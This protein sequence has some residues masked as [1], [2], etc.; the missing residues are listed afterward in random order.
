M[1]RWRQL[2]LHRAAVP[3]WSALLAAA[4][5][6]PFLGRG[7][8]LSYDMVWVPRLDLDRPEIWG[9]GTGLPRAVPSDAVVALLGAAVPA[10]VVQRLVL[11]AGLFLLAVGTA[12]LL[13]ERPLVAQLAAATLAVWNPFIAERL[14]L[15]QWPLLLACAAFPWLIDALG[16]KHDP[17]WSVASLALAATA[18][19][20]AT[21]VMGLVLALVAAW[22]RGVVGVVVLAALVN[23]PWVVAGLLHSSISRSDP[24]AVR[25][26]E[27]QPEG[28]FGRLGSA[29]TLGGI[30][31]TEVVPTSRTLVLTVVIAVAIG[32]VIAVGVVT[33]WRDDGRLLAVLA[34]AGGVG[35]AVA[36]LGW[37]DP[38]LVARVVRDVPGGGLVRDG[39]RWLALLVPLEAVAFG[40][41]VHTILYRAEFTAWEVPVVVLAL[42]LPLAALPDLA[43]GVGGRLE[44]ATYP[45]AWAD[46]RRVVEKSSVRGD[47][48][49]LPFSAY[50]KPSWNHDTSVLDP[51]GRFFDRTTVTNDD[52][53]VSGRT[54]DGEDPRA[55]R[56]QAV[57]EGRAVRRNLARQ[58]IGIVVVDTEAPGATDA[59]RSIRGARELDVQGDGLRLF[60][61][62]GARPR[63]IDDGDR[64]IMIATWIVTALTLAFATNG[65]I[66]GAV[67]RRRRKPV[68]S[69]SRTR[70]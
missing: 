56:V 17:R 70:P 43:W 66:R 22:R 16:G 24:A 28:H 20:P 15:G 48:L 53:V 64:Q 65:A 59:L 13:R 38:D 4:I 27:L 44:P 9:L 46:A 41:G 35:L 6:L 26:F 12:R 10:A 19:T 36:L 25:L 50:R 62:P 60:A 14:V 45:A 34:V 11:F 39:T 49:V 37:L 33:M 32:A 67:E 29:L 42:A 51:A 31:N 2:D 18:L 63:P 52:L 69:G 47:V 54:I 23:A 5:C 58:G 40:A 3:A 7:Y 8:V 30:W 21:G 61:L 1:R 57:L 55:E 68:P